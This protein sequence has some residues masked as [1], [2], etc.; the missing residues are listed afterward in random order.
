MFR[1]CDQVFEQFECLFRLLSKTFSEFSKKKC[2]EQGGFTVISKK[3][4][5]LLAFYAF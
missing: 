2:F 4:A 3:V 5:V 1:V